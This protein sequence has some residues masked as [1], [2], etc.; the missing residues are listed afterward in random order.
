M[1]ITFRQKDSGGNWT[2]SRKKF[3]WWQ[4]KGWGT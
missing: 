1:A 2:N 3:S 4:L